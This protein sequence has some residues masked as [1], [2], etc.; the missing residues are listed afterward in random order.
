MT[1]KE[2]KEREQ[3]LITEVTSLIKHFE[4]H[5]LTATR[6][7]AYTRLL[8][9]LRELNYRGLLDCVFAVKNTIVFSYLQ[10]LMKVERCGEDYVI[11][12]AWDGE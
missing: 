9:F 7:E 1:T 2:R 3:L 11:T 4:P 10:Q 6:N 12:L 8:F 5:A